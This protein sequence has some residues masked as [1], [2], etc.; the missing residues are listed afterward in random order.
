MMTTSLDTLARA[1]YSMPTA[2]AET[3][4]VRVLLFRGLGCLGLAGLV[5]A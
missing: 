4:I 5:R 3:G 2:H 1:G